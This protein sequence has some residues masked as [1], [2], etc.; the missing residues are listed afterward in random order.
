MPQDLHLYENSKIIDSQKKSRLV[1]ARG[2]EWREM[3]RGCV[4][5]TQLQPAT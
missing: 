4:M 5:G 3:G 1:V 2:W